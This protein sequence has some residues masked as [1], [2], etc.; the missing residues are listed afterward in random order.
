MLRRVK[1]QAAHKHVQMKS[2]AMDAGRPGVCAAARCLVPSAAAC[3]PPGTRIR[4]PAPAQTLCCH[5]TTHQL[6]TVVI[7]PTAHRPFPPTTTMPPKGTLRQHGVQACP[8]DLF[9]DSQSM[10]QKAAPV[11]MS[12]QKK[13]KRVS[14]NLFYFENSSK[15]YK[16]ES[17][18]EPYPDAD[19]LVVLPTAA[20]P[21]E[22]GL[23]G[24]QHSPLPAVLLR[25]FGHLRQLWQADPLH[26]PHYI[27]TVNSVTR[28]DLSPELGQS[29]DCVCQDEVGVE[30]GG[31]RG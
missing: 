29:P 19:P 25:N 14:K 31:R 5:D 15:R 1:Q 27:S 11:S 22:G 16:S 28:I 17:P 26:N 10:Q 3:P 2:A 20:D 21:G 30:R 23:E 4:S 6:T 18:G 12:L 7:T 8:P 13:V 9:C 24:G